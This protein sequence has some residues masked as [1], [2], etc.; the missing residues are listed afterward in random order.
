MKRFIIG[1]LYTILTVASCAIM[2]TW[3]FAKAGATSFD[4]PAIYPALAITWGLF[5]MG[6]L[7]LMR[8]DIERKK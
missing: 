4:V 5:L 2:M 6:K 8:A 7:A 1:G 3:F